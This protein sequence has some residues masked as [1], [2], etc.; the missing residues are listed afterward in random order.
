MCDYSFLKQKATDIRK[1]IVEMTHKVGSERK[2][3]PAPALSSAD[4]LSVLFFKQMNLDINQPKMK[5]RDRFILSKGHAAPVLYAALVQ[6]GIIH[7]DE[8]LSL[9]CVNSMLQ[10]HPDMKGTPGVD[11]TAGSLGHGISAGI[12]MAIAAKIDELDY[13]TYVVVGD[14]EIQEG[15]IWEAAEFAPHIKLDNLIVFVDKNGLQSCGSTHKI[16]NMEPLAEKWLSFG[17]N[18]IEIDGH[19]VEAIDN[20]VGDAKQVKGKPTVI[21]ANTVKGKGVSYM[22]NDN[23]WHQQ[24]L[25]KEQYDI[26]ISELS[27]DPEV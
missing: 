25:S 3:H 13:Y 2:A 17:W 4:I 8:M 18:V 9:R 22:E 20:A 1:D 12:G 19:D 21:I 14:G 27:A 6:K 15:L 24:A 5:Q 23:S 26:A 16:L 10:G 11:M 7:R